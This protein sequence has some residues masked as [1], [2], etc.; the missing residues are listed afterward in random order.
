MTFFKDW[1]VDSEE[2]DFLFE[3]A[4]N[5][6]QRK[7]IINETSNF[8]IK[9][10]KI[11]ENEQP[12]EESEEPVDNV[13]AYLQG[14]EQA[15][16]IWM[17]DEEEAG[18]VDDWWK[19][20]RILIRGYSSPKLSEVL[21]DSNFQSRLN[22]L[23]IYLKNSAFFLRA[24]EIQKFK[25]LLVDHGEFVKK[26]A[27][28]QNS[29]EKI[30]ARDI[31]ELND[32]KQRI[33]QLL[34]KLGYCSR[35][36]LNQNDKK[37]EFSEATKLCMQKCLGEK[38]EYDNFEFNENEFK[39]NKDE[40][41]QMLEFVLM[42]RIDKI[43]GS[44]LRQT[45]P[46]DP[47]DF[48]SK[49]RNII[50]NKILSRT[51]L[52]GKLRSDK[53]WKSLSFDDSDKGFLGYILKTS[54]R[55]TIFKLKSEDNTQKGGRGKTKNF[56]SI[57]MKDLLD[58]NP[59]TLNIY[60]YWHVSEFEKS[61]ILSKITNKSGKV[62]KA[63]KKRLEISS[64]FPQFIDK[65]DDLDIS[66]IE[67]DQ[68]LKEIL[69]LF[70]KNFNASGNSNVVSLDSLSSSDDDSSNIDL[71]STSGKVRTVPRSMAFI[72]D[73][74]IIGGSKDSTDVGMTQ[75]KQETNPVIAAVHRTLEKLING[76]SQ[77]NFYSEKLN[78]QV[79]YNEILALILA[80][81]YGIGY[82]IS[83]TGDIRIDPSQNIKISRVQGEKSNEISKI[84]EDK[85]GIKINPTSLRGKK[86]VGAAEDFMR[87]NLSDLET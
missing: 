11:I 2:D 60:R 85:L 38:N 74:D 1:L 39:Q 9:L 21:Q 46:I 77:E 68:G 70:A 81:K 15:K 14:S 82:T 58:N 19:D 83:S 41:M 43:K 55:N 6:I 45:P 66:M 26:L 34:K 27:D 69:K 16:P 12:E 76:P 10:F 37:Y 13:P 29:G 30:A 28:K 40:F 17:S 50:I 18:W 57:I 44:L 32:K 67:D 65:Y 49:V 5:C 84:L 54:G 47:D 20:S 61:Q 64:Y 8:L 73:E 48:R 72:G 22:E 23:Y 80:V 24:K 71:V 63:S 4:L 56:R 52:T 33:L 25:N 62:S 7:Y 86:W 79:S 78:R 36:K 53:D 31:A 87:Q 51:T 59:E 35:E 42:K 75:V 3:N